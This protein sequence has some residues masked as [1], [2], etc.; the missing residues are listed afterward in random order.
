M[1]G[2][3][4]KQTFV[5]IDFMTQ[6]SSKH[7]STSL[8]QNEHAFNFV[9]DVTLWLRFRPAGLETDDSTSS[10]NQLCVDSGLA[11]FC[12]FSR[13]FTPEGRLCRSQA[14]WYSRSVACIPSWDKIPLLSFVES[15]MTRLESCPTTGPELPSVIGSLLCPSSQPPASTSHCSSPIFSSPPATWSSPSSTCHSSSAIWHSSSA[16]SHLSSAVRH[17]PS[18][19]PAFP[20]RIPHSSQRV[21]RPQQLPCLGRLVP[22]VPLERRAAIERR[23]VGPIGVLGRFAGLVPGQQFLEPADVLIDDRVEHRPRLGRV[24]WSGSDLTPE[25]PVVEGGIGYRLYFLEVVPLL[26]GIFLD[27][28][29][30]GKEDGIERRVVDR[31]DNL[32]PVKPDEPEHFRH[33]PLRFAVQQVAVFRPA[34]QQPAAALGGFFDLADE[35]PWVV[36]PVRHPGDLDLFRP[37]DVQQP[38]AELANL[39]APRCAEHL[40]LDQLAALDRQRLPC[41]LADQVTL[42]ACR[43]RTESEP[44]SRGELSHPGHRLVSRSK[45]PS[46]GAEGTWSEAH[47]RNPLA[48]VALLDRHSGSLPARR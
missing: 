21:Q 3:D 12:A 22:P 36:G 7:P 48:R 32:F 14:P 45:C 10:G 42:D 20:F 30:P 19:I 34:L 8:D 6:K 1:L 16:I 47:G 11:S 38:A 5:S 9:G 2:K 13:V 4:E 43:S 35:Q 40:R 27:Q 28:H 24:A 33:F 23:A 37:G 39:R 29:V 44:L 25:Q 18:A 46:Q 26:L 41:R 17:P 15:A 31:L